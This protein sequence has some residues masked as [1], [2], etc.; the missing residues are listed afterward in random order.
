MSARCGPR[1]R[2]RRRLTSLPPAFRG[3]WRF[4]KRA[5]VIA[6]AALAPGRQALS[7][8]TGGQLP[9]SA[10][11]TVDE[12]V[13]RGEGRMTV[14]RGEER[15]VRA[16][17]TGVPP[18]H[19]AFVADAD[20]LVPR[21]AV[22]E[23]PRGRVLGPYRAVIT[24]SGTLVGELSPYFGTRTPNENPVFI[25]MRPPAPT[26]ATDRIGVL[27]ARGDV[28][29]YHYLTDVLPRLAIL[30]GID[31]PVQRLYVPAS[32]PFQRQLLELLGIPAERVIDA[33]RVRHLQAETLVV[34]GLPDADLKTPPWVVS[35]LR[36][37][38]LE[39]AFE[40]VPGTR[41]YLTRGSR[42]G[43]RIVTNEAEVVRALAPLG[44][45][46]IDPGA[47][48]VAEQIATFAGAEWIVAPHGAALTNLAFA[49]PGAAVVE[50]FAPDY[51]QGCY[52]KISECV[53]GLSYRYLVGAGRPRP[54]NRMDGVDSDITVDVG[55]LHALLEGLPRD[56]QV[57][58]GEAVPGP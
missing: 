33:D 22:A 37:R 14:A 1:I 57:V 48:P 54:H 38:L 25:D 36:E 7:R 10:A 55:A 44:F 28:S 3:L 43:N 40:R 30:E 27:A 34:P 58:R 12:V 24:T 29:Y 6:T 50:L 23:L 20:E 17:P 46:V 4:A 41:L 35:F 56:D 26:F 45:T 9:G 31:A 13:A 42:R 21:L 47:L 52:W 15:L 5:H 16:V 19:P 53:P 51:V 8:W 11:R 39:P 2:T 18:E 49:T 32:L